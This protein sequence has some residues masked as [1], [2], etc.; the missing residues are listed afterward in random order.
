[1]ETNEEEGCC[2]EESKYTMNEAFEEGV[3]Q[4]IDHT[5]NN[6]ATGEGQNSRRGASQ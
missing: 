1:M 3:A 6:K 4:S 2:P 5:P